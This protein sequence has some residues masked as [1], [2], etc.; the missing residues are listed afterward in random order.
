MRIFSIFVL[1]LLSLSLTGCSSMFNN[2][3][4]YSQSSS[5]VD[6]L[7]PNN[8]KSQEHKTGKPN[9]NLPLK[10]GLAFV[11]P[12]NSYRQ[13]SQ[14]NQ[15]AL[16]QKVKAAFSHYPFISE[17]TVIPSNYM[18]AG[19]GF[20]TIDQLSRLYD[21]D[22]MA[23]VSYD[24][25]ST[26]RENNAALLYWTIVGMY[27]IPGN[28]NSVQTFVDTAVFD[29][30]SRKLLVRAPGI[31]KLEKISTA[32]GASDVRRDQSIKGFQLAVADMNKNLDAEMQN[33]KARIKSDN[34]ATVTYQE[35]HSA[36]SAGGG[37]TMP[38]MLLLGLLVALR[39]IRRTQRYV[40]QYIKNY[41]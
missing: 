17:I 12:K 26:T 15:L 28:S 36:S 27:L 20:A 31:S 13:I 1:A 37:F 19:G 11:P 33:F 39:F 32:V 14:A 24:Q 5:L 7:Y 10:I 18:R 35:G 21:L 25:L 29:I 2:G 6:F 38:L 30:K 4:D 41:P 3:R 22:V 8:K 23:L 40:G 16:L 9:L 34:V